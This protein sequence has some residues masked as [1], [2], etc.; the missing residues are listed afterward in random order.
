MIRT[1]STISMEAWDKLYK[2]NLD[3]NHAW[4]AAPANIIVRKLM[5]V[6]PLTPGGELIQ[7][8]PQL[9]GLSFARLET[10]MLKGKVLVSCKKNTDEESME[11]IIPGDTKANIYLACDSN[12]T[13]LW[14]D[15]KRT[16]LTPQG[17]FFIIKNV[18]AGRHFF[19]KQ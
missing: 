17:G 5:G 12:K 1:G 4:G 14:M 15:G 16:T 13:A 8:K 9:G 7:I 2:P 10:T 18:S 6:E 3:L 11:V 19:I